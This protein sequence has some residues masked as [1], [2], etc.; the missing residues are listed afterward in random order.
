MPE[1]LFLMCR[2]CHDI[3]PNTIFPEIFFQWVRSQ[4][5]SAREQHKLSEAFRSFASEPIEREA[6]ERTL[7]S[8]EFNT[9][10]N[11]MFGLH[12]PQSNYASCS[13]R[14]TPSTIVGLASYYLKHIK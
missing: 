2:E 7:L 11:G 12:R 10:V 8:I 4:H 9:W 14:L 1:N 5:W 6:V 13:S 3:A